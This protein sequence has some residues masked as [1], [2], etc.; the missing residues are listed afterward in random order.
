MMSVAGVPNPLAEGSASADERANLTWTWAAFGVALLALAGSLHLSL[1]MGLQA[2]T[3]CFYQ[4]AFVMSLVA[5]LG[6]GLLAG[7][8][9]RVRLS[10][11]ALP[12]A[13]AGL[14]VAGFHVSLELRGILECPDGMF[15][16]GTA[17]KQSFLMF[18][19]LTGFLVLDLLALP[20]DLAGACKALTSGVVLGGLLALGSC[21]SNPPMRLPPDKPYDK[22][23]D[24]C[25]PPARITAG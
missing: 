5:V 16:L 21:T 1:G 6:M 12:L 2:C 18:L 19:V 14:G 22:P 9:R 8:Y 4:R 17:P 10:V 3:L 25:R 15:G 11:L 13:I 20:R 24:T 23:P 7:A